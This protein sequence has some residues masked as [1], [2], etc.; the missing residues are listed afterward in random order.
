MLYKNVSYHEHAQAPIE[1]HICRVFNRH[2]FLS[3]HSND[4]SEQH[5]QDQT[6]IALHVEA[7]YGTPK[8]SP[9]PWA[10]HCVSLHNNPS[11]PSN[12]PYLAEYTF[13]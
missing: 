9:W 6:S 7:S 1:E 8:F 11:M 3:L 12:A 10:G 4:T 2:R 5:G 13:Y